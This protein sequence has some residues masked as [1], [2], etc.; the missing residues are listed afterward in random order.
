M[1]I[2]GKARHKIES[3]QHSNAEFTWLENEDTTGMN[4]PQ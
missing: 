1:Y 4:D 2:A 3:V